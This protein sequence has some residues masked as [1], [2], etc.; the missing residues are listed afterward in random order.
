MKQCTRIAE[1]QE[2]CLRLAK[3]EIGEKETPPG[4]KE[5]PPG[6]KEKSGE[7]VNFAGEKDFIRA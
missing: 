2:D 3:L 7:K 6:K 4:E 5:T 1:T